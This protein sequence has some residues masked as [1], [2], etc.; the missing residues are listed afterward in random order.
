MR[1]AVI[2]GTLVIA[3]CLP[4]ITIAQDAQ[5]EYGEALLD[6]ALI[7]IDNVNATLPD[8]TALNDSLHVVGDAL[9]DLKSART[10]DNA[11]LD[12]IDALETL[13]GAE[14]R[15]LDEMLSQQPVWEKIDG[16]K[17]LLRWS[18]EGVANEVASLAANRKKD[19]AKI[20]AALT[21]K[22][23][24]RTRA[25]RR[26]KPGS[27]EGIQSGATR[28]GSDEPEQRRCG[29]ER[30]C[31]WYLELLAG[32]TTHTTSG[33]LL[34]AQDQELDLSLGYYVGLGRLGERHS[35][36]LSTA[37]SGAADLDDGSFTT[38]LGSFERRSTTALWNWAFTSGRLFSFRVIGEYQDSRLTFTNT[39]VPFVEAKTQLAGV[40]FGIGKWSDQRKRG[41]VLTL[42]W[43]RGSSDIA[44]QNLQ[45]I[46][47][48]DLWSAKAEIKGGVPLSRRLGMIFALHYEKTE[49]EDEFALFVTPSQFVLSQLDQTWGVRVG[50]RILLR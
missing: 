35:F 10:L 6:V 29:R 15:L 36:S 39:F 40:G 25:V 28:D 13:A 37:Q 27:R 8:E 49:Y 20:I 47:D 32:T 7:L 23:A 16:L 4:V 24:K 1:H 34:F 22:V 46:T 2:L 38:P 50:L 41:A 21:P 43:R 12:E 14:A 3:S 18:I 44:E 33:D 31:R 5:T 9:V 45:S 42:D 11:E 30:P 26:P 17:T 48:V 19:I